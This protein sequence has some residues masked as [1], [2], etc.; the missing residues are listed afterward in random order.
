MSS[1]NEQWVPGALVEI[2]CDIQ[3]SFWALLGEGKNPGTITVGRSPVMWWPRD[4]DRPETFRG[5]TLKLLLPAAASMAECMMAM[6]GLPG[7]HRPLAPTLEQ[8]LQAPVSVDIPLEAGHAS[9]SAAAGFDNYRPS[10]G[11]VT[12]ANIEAVE[13]DLHKVK[14]LRT[15]LDGVKQQAAPSAQRSSN[16][17]Q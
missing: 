3:G 8:S 9:F 1:S 12:A 15:Y 17:Q 11:F 16:E 4:L 13:R 7:V 6:C 2:V 5:Q 10:G 14:A